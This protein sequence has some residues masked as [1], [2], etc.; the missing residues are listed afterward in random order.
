MRVT[1]D[2]DYP[3]E[4]GL[5][6]AYYNMK[7][8]A[9]GGTAFDARISAHED[10]I[11][12]I[13]YGLPITFEQSLMLRELMVDDPVRRKFDEDPQGKPTQVLYVKKGE[14][15]TRPL[16]RNTLLAKPFWSKLVRGRKQRTK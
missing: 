15:R 4:L 2:V 7:Y 14:H 10:G 13:V 5:L 1:V 12:M 8:L 6:K 11:H 3:T 16:F 9:R